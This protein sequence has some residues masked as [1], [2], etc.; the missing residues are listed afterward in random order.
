[1]PRKSAACW[2]LS[3]VVDGWSVDVVVIARTVL[4]VCSTQIDQLTSANEYYEAAVP[5]VTAMFIAA[6]NVSKSSG[7]IWE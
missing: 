7:S 6:A 5:V 1:M 4:N 3:R 2:V